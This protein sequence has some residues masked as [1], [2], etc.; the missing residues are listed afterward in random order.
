[1]FQNGGGQL[2]QNCPAKRVN[3]KGQCL[4][5]DKEGEQSVQPNKEQDIID[6]EESEILVYKQTS[7][8]RLVI[9]LTIISLKQ[10]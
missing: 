2:N 3:Q 7:E 5:Q 8:R 9:P 1:M 6:K 10:Q 4:A